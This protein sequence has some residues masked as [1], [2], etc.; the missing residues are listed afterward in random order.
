MNNLLPL[1]E[2]THI[3][4]WLHVF[5]CKASLGVFNHVISFIVLQRNMRDWWRPT[6]QSTKNCSIPYQNKLVYRKQSWIWRFVGY[7]APLF[8]PISLHFVLM[9]DI[10][11]GFEE[12]WARFCCFTE[13]SCWPSETGYSF[14]VVAVFQSNLWHIRCIFVNKMQC[15]PE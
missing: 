1:F 8:H 7:A 5:K 6:L 13:R 9:H 15:F 11:G 14:V 12:A 4:M 2:S 3:F 10:S